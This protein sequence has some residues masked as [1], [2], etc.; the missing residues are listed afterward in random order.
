MTQKVWLVLKPNPLVVWEVKNDQISVR[1]RIPKVHFRFRKCY[2]ADDAPWWPLERRDLYR[3]LSILYRFWYY[4][5][6]RSCEKWFLPGVLCCIWS[7]YCFQ[8]MG[9]QTPQIHL[10]AV[11]LSTLNSISYNKEMMVL[12]LCW[13]YSA[14][15]RN[16]LKYKRLRILFTKV[17]FEMSNNAE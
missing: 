1:S 15:P 5:S 17:K 16:A 7:A 12:E 11:H 4:I 9:R 2:G 8:Y 14:V 3:L 10:N 13:R 6:Y